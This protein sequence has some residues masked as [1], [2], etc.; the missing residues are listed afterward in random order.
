MGK[1]APRWCLKTW[2]SFLLPD[3][4]HFLTRWGYQRPRVHCGH[5]WGT[6]PAG[7]LSVPFAVWLSWT[8][9]SSTGAEALLFSPGRDRGLDSWPE[10]LQTVSLLDQGGSCSRV[11]GG[12]PWRAP[13]ECLEGSPHEY[14]ATRCRWWA[15]ALLLQPP[16]WSTPR[17][18]CLLWGGAVN[19][20]ANFH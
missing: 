8:F 11:V 19:S 4:W 7:L 2:H 9:P 5:P 1:S 20:L 3:I 14:D 10:L 18:I 6:G 12:I 17:Q 15:T 16:R 13:E